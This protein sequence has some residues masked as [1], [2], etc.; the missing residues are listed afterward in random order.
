MK[1]LFIL[2][3]AFTLGASAQAQFKPRAAFD[4]FP[5]GYNTKTIQPVAP[6]TGMDQSVAV[7]SYG[8][9]RVRIGADYRFKRFS[10]YFDQHVYMVKDQS[11]TFRPLQV[12]WYAGFKYRI[13]TNIH[14]QVEHLC[15]HPVASDRQNLIF[16]PRVL[17]GYNMLSINYG[18]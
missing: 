18:Y 13:G 10:A 16:Q 17:G 6:S 9:F 7:M 5:G 1:K 12:D 3:F 4:F 11:F 15:I 14:I 2:A 8:T